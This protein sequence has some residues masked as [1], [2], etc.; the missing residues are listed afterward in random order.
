MPNN[1]ILSKAVDVGQSIPPIHP[2]RKFLM[3]SDLVVVDSSSRSE[4]GVH[5]FYVLACN[6]RSILNVS[7]RDQPLLPF[8]HKVFKTSHAPNP[9][10]ESTL[11]GN[12]E[13]AYPG[14]EARRLTS[15]VPLPTY[16]CVPTKRTKDRSCS[17]YV[18][19]VLQTTK[20]FEF[21]PV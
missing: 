4:G 21:T 7:T 5:Q 3:P 16:S 12:D 1:A 11:D 20:F 15:Q 18:P 2:L 6:K 13:I 14:S 19:P 8:Y 9:S 17:W 10:S